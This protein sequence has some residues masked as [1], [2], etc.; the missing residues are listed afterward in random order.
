MR[1]IQE[2]SKATSELHATQMLSTTFPPVSA[3][4]FS[5]YDG[6]PLPATA[7]KMALASD[8]E[9]SVATDSGVVPDRYALPADFP[10]GG[11]DA[12]LCVFGGWCA[13]FAAFGLVNCLG[14]FL[15]YYVEGPLSP[16]GSSAVSWIVTVQLYFQSGSAIVWGRLY[17]VYGP[18]WLLYGG[19]LMYIF[20][21]MMTSLATQYYQ[22]F[23]AQSLVSAMGS[24]AI[25]NVSLTC[26]TTWFHKK[27][28]AAMGI[29]VS[30]S[31]LGGVILPI[32]FNQLIPR[33]GFPWT[34]RIVA[35]IL[36]ALC[37][38]ACLTIKSRLPPRPKALK[39]RDYVRPLTEPAFLFTV[40]SGFFFLLGMFI[41]FNYVTLQAEAAGVSPNLVPYLLSIIN[42]VSIFGRIIPGFIADVV[43]RYNTMIIITALSAVFTLSLW[44][45]GRGSAAIVVYGAIFGFTSGGY[46][47]IGAPCIAQISDIREIGTRTGTAYLLQALGGL[48]GS[49]IAGALVSKMGGNYLGLQLFCGIS[50]CVSVA[51]NLAAR[52]AQVGFKLAKV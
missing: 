12:W 8:I 52:H 38:A 23:L 32:I 2:K 35:L 39:A 9:E 36:L 20:G 47:S 51:F 30:G 41:P 17:D 31:S 24:G 21:L 33:L 49:P 3:P 44:I 45:P 43:G 16:Y 19:S 50:M 10:D 27:R 46:V 25:F 11:L 4:A 6:Q 26:A 7:E 14:V 13:M 40:L 5:I 1:E 29:L 37:S 15:T 28:A 48:I 34:L 42:G 18:K 22:I